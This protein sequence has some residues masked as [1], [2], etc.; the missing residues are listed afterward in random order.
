MDDISISVPHVEHLI[1]GR[2]LE[3]LKASILSF[4]NPGR[5]NSAPNF[6]R[7]I[8]PKIP[9]V[10]KQ[11][12]PVDGDNDPTDQC[13]VN[14]FRSVRPRQGEDASTVCDQCSISYRDPWIHA[15]KD[16]GKSS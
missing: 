15:I 4:C 11:A 10:N 12:R 5:R 3:G 16:R 7:S 1:A 9:V 6:L 2:M 13:D 14:G 8:V